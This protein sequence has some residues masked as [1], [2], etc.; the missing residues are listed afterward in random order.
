MHFI[1]PDGLPDPM[2]WM[3]EG[4][5]TVHAAAG[6]AEI[7]GG[8]GLILPGLTGIRP[9]LAA[10]AAVGLVIVMKGAIIWHSGRGEAFS[11]GQNILYT[12]VLGFIAYG[13]WKLAPLARGGQ[14]TAVT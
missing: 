10:F 4:D 14:E 3:Y 13:R 7:L 6:V 5:D 11:I 2:S 9:E 1:V 8:L 12:V